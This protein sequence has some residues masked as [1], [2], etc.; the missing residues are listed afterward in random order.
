MG[1][2][3]MFK[4]ICLLEDGI[5]IV[6]SPRK[7]GNVTAPRPKEQGFHGFLCRQIAIPI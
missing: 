5:G 1:K 6:G 7:N 2:A 3:R 4:L